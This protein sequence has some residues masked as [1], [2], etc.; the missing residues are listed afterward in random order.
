MTWKTIFIFVVLATF[1]IL[2][3]GWLTSIGVLPISHV[4]NYSPAEMSFIRV[5]TRLA[6]TIGIILPTIAF[7]VW[8]KSPEVRKIYRI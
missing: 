8:F 3:V 6:I 5:W 2:L 7:I 4:I 1:I